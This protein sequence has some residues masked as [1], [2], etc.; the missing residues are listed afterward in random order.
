MRA[1]CAA[2]LARLDHSPPQLTLGSNGA[3]TVAGLGVT[4]VSR[5]AMHRELDTGTLVELPRPRHPRSRG[6]GM[7]SPSRTRHRP[8][9]C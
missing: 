6:R 4:L 9:G 5:Q 1:T 2:L 3:V 8:R 7:S